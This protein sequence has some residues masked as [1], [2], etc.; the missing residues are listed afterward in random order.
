MSE[1]KEPISL[2]ELKEIKEE[3]TKLI[4]IPD[5]DYEGTIT[6]K[7]KKKIDMTEE[8]LQMDNIPNTLVGD[9]EEAFSVES[10]EKVKEKYQEK[11]AKSK[12][13]EKQKML[14]DL[15]PVVEHIAKAVLVQPT[16]EEFEKTNP[17]TLMQKM[18]I[19]KQVS[20]GINA[21]RPFR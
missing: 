18:E 21:L 16:Y 12:I 7:V 14:K 13:E 19:F 10:P 2:E 5:W 6:V 15:K 1:D 8:I 3:S 17:L 9:A 4:D 20:G 11:Y